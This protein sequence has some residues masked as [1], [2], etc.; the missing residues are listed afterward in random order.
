MILERTIY[1]P[2]GI[3]GVLTHDDHTEI[4]RTLEH[5]YEQPDGSFRPKVKAGVYMCIKGIHRLTKG[6]PF[7][8]FEVV[9]VKGH[10]GI[11]FHTG[12]TNADSAG[13]ILVGKKI[14]N[15]ALVQSRVAFLDLMVILGKTETFP[16]L[17]I[18]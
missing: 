15:K 11:L 16:L 1:S 4:C 14:E 18:G 10:S 12:N 6:D 2:Y 5:A 7:E 3:F 8:T 9:G 17:V 13:C